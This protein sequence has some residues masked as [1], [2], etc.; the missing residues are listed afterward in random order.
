MK[1]Y[2][3]SEK[4]LSKGNYHRENNIMNT[5]TDYNETNP[6]KDNYPSNNTKESINTISE[7]YRNNTN[8]NLSS[9]YSN[10]RDDK[11]FN[12]EFKN[13]GL[14]NNNNNNNIGLNSLSNTTKLD[15]NMKIRDSVKFSNISNLEFLNQKYYK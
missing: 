4:D 9:K 14:N 13:E 12:N 8:N 2:L 3:P 6:N 1:N 7:R 11:I 10:I 5:N 15:K